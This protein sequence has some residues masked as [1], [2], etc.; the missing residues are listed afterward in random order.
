MPLKHGQVWGIHHLLR[1]RILI[2]EYKKYFDTFRNCLFQNIVPMETFG[3]RCNMLV[4]TL[5][6]EKFFSHVA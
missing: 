1:Y 6:V 3:P 4:C 5:C 2:S